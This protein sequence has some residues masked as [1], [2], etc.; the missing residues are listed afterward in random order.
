MSGKKEYYNR[1]GITPETKVFAEEF[2]KSQY[3][4][5]TGEEIMGST[6]V[7]YYID[8]GAVNAYSIIIAHGKVRSV[9]INT[10]ATAFKLIDSGATFIASGIKVGHTVLN[11]TG[12]T[13]TKVAS[14]DSETQLT[15]NTDIF[16]ATSKSYK[17]GADLFQ[18]PQSYVAGQAFYIKITNDNTGAATLNINAIGA[19][20]I[21]RPDGSD[22]QAG[23]IIAGRIY[24][25]IHDAVNFVLLNAIPQDYAFNNLIKNGSFESWSAGASNEAPD[26]WS[27]IGAPTD[28]SRDTGVRDN[29]GNP[30]AVKITSDG[31]GNEGITVTLS[32][33]KKSTTYSIK[34]Q[35]KATAGDTAKI[36]TTGGDTDL[37]KTTTS[38]SWVTLTGSFITNDTP[39]DIV[40]KLGSDNATDIVWFDSLIVTEGEAAFAFAP[41]PNDEHLKAV[42][43]QDIV[44]DNYKYSLFRIECGVAQ[45]S[46][47]GTTTITFGESFS[48]ILVILGS[49]ASDA[50]NRRFP[51]IFNRATTGFDCKLNNLASG[52]VLTAGNI[53]WI[54]IGVD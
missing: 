36:W 48:K 32:N 26:G 35:A 46:G 24:E 47:S 3:A 21:K 16:Q 45:Y 44:P 20:A 42:N 49:G 17:V 53:W 4:I 10:T 11:L 6:P 34:I 23:D 25:I 50:A 33:L 39:A 37:S 28:I 52:W 7:N 51:S 27:K 1:I 14:I 12:T 5:P 22:L 31:A 19:T 29:F 8:I 43:Y 30:Y 9:G 40:L 18:L 38:E 2:N 15:L 41:H 54:A 13:E